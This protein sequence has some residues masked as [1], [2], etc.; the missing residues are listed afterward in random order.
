M[1]S[2]QLFFQVQVILVDIFLLN[3]LYYH[4]LMSNLKILILN[5]FVDNVHNIILLNIHIYKIHKFF[6]F[7]HYSSFYFD[8]IIYSLFLSLQFFHP[9]KGIYQLGPFFV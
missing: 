4:F 7:H 3:Y 6:Y 5:N 9:L 1:E 8:Y 2:I